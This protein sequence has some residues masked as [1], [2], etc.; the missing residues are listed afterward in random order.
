MDSLQV[1]TGQIS[2][3]ILDDEGEE[4]GIFSFNPEDVESAKQVVLLQ[5]E[6]KVKNEEFDKQIEE[7]ET[8]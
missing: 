8:P 5:E 2:L 7:C 1:R 6:L 3:R 4:R